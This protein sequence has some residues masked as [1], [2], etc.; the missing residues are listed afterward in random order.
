MYEED[1]SVLKE[2]ANKASTKAYTG[3]TA[4]D[5]VDDVYAISM[6]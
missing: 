3:L 4:A 6:A 1:G 5:D 2:Q